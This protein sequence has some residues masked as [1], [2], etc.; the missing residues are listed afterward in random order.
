MAHG[1]QDSGGSGGGQSAALDGRRAFAERLYIGLHSPE[2]RCATV[3]R[4][5]GWS[6]EGFTGASPPSRAWPPIPLRP[7]LRLEVWCIE[8]LM[9]PAQSS[10]ATSEKARVLPR[11]FGAGKPPDLVLAFGTAGSREGVAANG[12]VVI[13]RRTLGSTGCRVASLVTAHLDCLR[14]RFH[15]P[16][17]AEWPPLS[18]FGGPLAPSFPC[19]PSLYHPSYLLGSYS[20][21]TYASNG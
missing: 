13:G 18:Q 17:G 4:A 7:S 6:A 8:E 3:T 1:R 11:A 16:P 12:S 19:S 5:A 9:N 20:E 21:D 2:P 14:H 15:I 10:S